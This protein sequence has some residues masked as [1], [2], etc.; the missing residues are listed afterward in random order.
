MTQARHTNRNRPSTCI[1]GAGASGIAA[2]KA[3]REAGVPFDCFEL[4]S[5]IGGIW[6]YNNDSGLSPAYKSLH[7]NTSRQK[8]AFS[9]FP[10]PRDYP[11]FPHHS[12]ILDYFERYVDHF[13]FRDAI[14]FR[15]RVCNVAPV[16][17]GCWDVTTQRRGSEARQTR[18]YAAVVVAN[19]HHSSPRRPDFP[20]EFANPAMHSSEYREPEPMRGER[21]LVVG[22]GN[23]GC[24]IACEVSRTAERVFL[25]TRRGAH[26]IPK[27]LFGKPLDRLAPAWMWRYLP[28][29]AFQKI[30]AWSLRLSRGR[31]RK[32]G[33]PEPDHR[34]LEEH[35]TIS[36]E[37]LNLLGHGRIGIKPNVSRL[38]GD[39]VEFADG[40]SESIDRIIYATGYDITFPFLD[41]RVLKTE[42]N[43]VRL[44]RRV[45]HPRY[46]NLLFVGLVQ[47]W[48][49]VMPLA[50]AQS[51]WV[52]D[53]LTG[54]CG[55][56]AEA[57]MQ[58]TIDRCDAAVDRR[59]TRTARHTIQVDFY[60]Y[61][62]ELRKERKRGRRREPIVFP[63]ERYRVER[64]A[65]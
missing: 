50:E 54:V 42:G 5:G 65:A 27:Y 16:P 35:P 64:R 36:G 7:I 55:L 22:M 19:G 2:A 44:Y 29:R 63:V 12:Q 28:F 46:R 56:P 57:V 8:M 53:L 48:G 60:A 33:L 49:S 34:I 32:Y 23:S 47:P 1:I 13:G 39:R 10:M 52:A 37:L 31:L 41:S 14:Q 40:T 26:V 45:V 9:D 58:R 18:R 24:D 15:T 20:G 62:D 38:A 59:Y 6:R 21:V 3:L 4:G 25:S 61:H 43:R 30:F 11:D 51:R 17:G